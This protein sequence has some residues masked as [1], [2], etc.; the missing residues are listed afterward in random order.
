M[1][2]CGDEILVQAT[3]YLPIARGPVAVEV[4]EVQ[5]H[6]FRLV[7]VSGEVMRSIGL[8]ATHA[9][10]GISYVGRESV[11][12]FGIPW[13]VMNNRRSHAI[14]IWSNQDAGKKGHCK[15]GNSDFCHL[16]SV[17]RMSNQR[18]HAEVSNARQA[19]DLS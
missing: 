3:S 17:L 7:Q 11:D 1:G 12:M 4:F 19:I 16:Q 18:Y 10:H 8:Y 14:R 6:Y 15:E 13:V 5:S 9:K 2:T